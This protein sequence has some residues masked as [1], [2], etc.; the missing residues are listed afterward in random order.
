MVGTTVG[1]N[2]QTGSGFAIA[3]GNSIFCSCPRRDDASF[4]VVF[5]SAFPT[6]GLEVNG[7][8]CD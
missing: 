1:F 5:C 8:L 3:R 7:V 2:A 4:R 6:P